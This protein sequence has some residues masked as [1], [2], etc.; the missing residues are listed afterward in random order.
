MPGHRPR[1][2]GGPAN[3]P[4]LKRGERAYISRTAIGLIRKANLANCLPNFTLMA[5]LLGVSRS[6][7][8]KVVSNK[9]YYSA[10]YQ[11]KLDDLDARRR[12][13][14]EELAG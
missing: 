7:I 3:E 4:S 6:M 14:L 1:Q 10:A 12:A 11:S 2:R 5:N 9:T 13:V 8:G